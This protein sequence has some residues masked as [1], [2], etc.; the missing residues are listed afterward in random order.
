[1]SAKIVLATKRLYRK[2]LAN[3]RKADMTAICGMT[4]K[5]WN[6]TDAKPAIATTSELDTSCQVMIV[7]PLVM[8]EPKSTTEK[9]ERSEIFGANMA[10]LKANPAVKIAW[11]EEQELLKWR[12]SARDEFLAECVHL[13]TCNEYHYNLLSTY[14]KKTPMSILRTPIDADF[15]KPAK[16]RRKGVALGRVC[17]AKNIEGVLEVFRHLPD[18]IE[19]VYIGNQG[20]WGSKTN[21]DNTRLEEQIEELATRWIPAADRNEVAM[22]LST[23]AAYFNVSI[24]DVGCLSFLES[25]MSGCHCFAWRFHPM[26]DEYENCYRFDS[27]KEGAQ[28]IAD[29]L[30]A[31][32]GK[33]DMEMRAEVEALHSYE[34]FTDQ[35]QKLILGVFDV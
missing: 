15:Y 7:E 16:K 6:T 32:Q 20:L 11:A 1:M 24:Y 23:A 27:Y 25:A 3:M 13:A 28:L 4:S 17:T 2:N 14:V 34:S 10:L 9:M 8:H 21:E 30:D 19:T 5:T 35:L 26:F 12:G 29:V 31:S 18:D 22:E 33:A